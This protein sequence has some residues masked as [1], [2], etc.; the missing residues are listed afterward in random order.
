MG[1]YYRWIAPLEFDGE[2]T[3]VF[4]QGE[5]VHINIGG[6]IDHFLELDLEEA[7]H[8]GSL[9]LRAIYSDGIPFKNAEGS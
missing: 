1:R 9:L 3:R 7:D 2:Q 4:R 6:C 5:K 8:L